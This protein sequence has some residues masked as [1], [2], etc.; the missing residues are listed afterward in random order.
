MTKSVSDKGMRVAILVDA[1]NI[2]AG[3]WPMI[4]QV[5]SGLGSATILTCFAD[6]SNKAHAGWLDIC[7][8]N[9]G[10]AVMVLK[11]GDRKNGSDIALTIEAMELLHSGSAEMFIIVSSDSDFAP[12]AQKITASGGIAVGIGRHMATEG[13]KRAFDRYVV[14]PT[15][16]R[17]KTAVEPAPQTL[18]ADQIAQLSA[19]VVRLSRQEADGSVLLSR[20]GMVLRKEHPKLAAALAKGRLRKALKRYGLAVEQGTGTAIRVAPPK[21]NPSMAPAGKDLKQTG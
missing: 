11:T 5:V 3:N 16:A 19:L 18:P 8:D 20:L 9:G 2:S 14:L 10:T 17:A 12:L 1:E 21:A 15:E 4:G 6:F 13:L 7:R